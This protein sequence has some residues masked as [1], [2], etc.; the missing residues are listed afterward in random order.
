MTCGVFGCHW[1]LLAR[2]LPPPGS[3][4]NGSMRGE[5]DPARAPAGV[6]GPG[7]PRWIRRRL[8]TR[9]WE[10]IARRRCCAGSP[11]RSRWHAS[12]P[13]RRA[14]ATERR[15]RPGTPPWKPGWWPRTRSGGRRRRTS[16]SRLP[17]RWRRPTSS[18]RT[19]RRWRRRPH[20]ATLRNPA[21]CPTRTRRPH[22]GRAG[23]ERPWTSS[24]STP[25]S[26]PQTHGDT[27]CW[28]SRGGRP[29]IWESRKPTFSGPR[30]CGRT[31]WPRR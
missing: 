13:W 22:S 5:R 4:I 26:A 16:T 8:G 21:R 7:R 29:A 24:R 11:W 3:R 28:G 10:R 6:P 31:T 12:W 30:S 17:R 23:T 1:H 2:R 15:R 20:R 18:A 27:T 9:R 14:G 25:R 19:R